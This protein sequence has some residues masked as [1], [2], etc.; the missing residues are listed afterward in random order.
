MEVLNCRSPWPSA[1][2]ASGRR[3]GPRKTSATPSRMIR[4]VG[5]SSPE[6][7]S[8]SFRVVG[9][10]AAALVCSRG[11]PWDDW[12]AVLTALAPAFSAG[13]GARQVISDLT[14]RGI[15]RAS[16]LHDRVEEPV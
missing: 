1:R 4:W 7:T 16:Q 13:S 11:R 5:C 9:L 12:E 3:R 8:G 14:L 2:P 15:G 6:N 10:A